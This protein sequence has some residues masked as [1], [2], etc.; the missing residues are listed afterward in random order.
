MDDEDRFSEIRKFKTFIRIKNTVLFSLII[1]D[2]IFIF[3]RPFIHKT[4]DI[5]YF[6]DCFD[7]ITCICLF[8]DLIYKYHYSHESTLSFIKSNLLDIIAIIPLPVMYLRFLAV[9]RILRI[10]GLIGL[11]NK[12]KDADEEKITS[13][14]DFIKENIFITSIVFAII[15]FTVVSIFI[16][17]FD[18]SVNG[19][20]E[21]IWFNLET[22]TTVG[23]GDIIPATVLGKSTT[24]ITVIVGAFFISMFTAYLSALYNEKPEKERRKVIEGYMD[25]LKTRSGQVKEEVNQLDDHVNTIESDVQKLED[26]MDKIILYLQIREQQKNNK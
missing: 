16:D 3:L 1:I 26:E 22:I 21:S 23:Y 25:E 9:F 14:R 11:I 19:L 20:F 8:L 24:I 12:S 17:F 18:L 10:F 7:L 5:D 15:Y 2:L 6:M 4:L 13:R